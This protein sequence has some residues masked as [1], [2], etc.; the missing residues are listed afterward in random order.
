MWNENRAEEFSLLSFTMEKLLPRTCDV[1]W[2]RQGKH[3]NINKH[4]SDKQKV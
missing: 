3:V 2:E 4:R 1:G